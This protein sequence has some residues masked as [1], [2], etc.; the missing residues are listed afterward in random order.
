[1]KC[2][3]K[4][5]LSIST[6]LFSSPY[7]C[8]AEPLS[9]S[10]QDSL[11]VQV[12]FQR[13]YRGV[14]LHF[15]SNRERL[16]SFFRALDSLRLSEGVRIMNSAL[17]ES[18]C[19]PEGSLSANAALSLRRAESLISLSRGRGLG[20]AVFSVMSAGADRAGLLPYLSGSSLEEEHFYPLLRQARLTITY[21]CL[22][23]PAP[24]TRF[25]TR[26]VASQASPAY[27][28]HTLNEAR[29]LPQKPVLALR[30]NLLA[31][32][33]TSVNLGLEIPLGDHFSLGGDLHLP[34]WRLRREDITFQLAHASAELRWY[35]GNS[36]ER[37]T[38]F[39]A[40]LFVSAGLYDLQAGRLSS[41]RGVQGEFIMPAGLSAGYS[42]RVGRR[43]LLSYGAGAGYIRSDYH[44]Y[45]MAHGT[46]HGDIKVISHPWE[47]RRLTGVIPA[48]LSV[49]LSWTVFGRRRAAL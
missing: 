48:R 36:R 19:S 20:D 10:P 25:P 12:F 13:G 14:D 11:S 38:G 39:Y 16:D 29:T 34:W 22:D 45:R 3:A 6:V 26:A 32:A 47:R 46:A 7:F 15:S 37:L 21:D 5:L 49:A 24:E 2:K 35:P 1:M 8:G 41:G 28:R 18:S 4:I 40:G 30:T 31:D 9:D 43:L 23:L 33:V 44:R 17:V 42:H 27:P